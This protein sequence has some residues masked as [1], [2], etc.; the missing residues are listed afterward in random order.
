[1]GPIS[2]ENNSFDFCLNLLIIEFFVRVDTSELFR[3]KYPQ[4]IVLFAKLL[5]SLLDFLNI[6]ICWKSLCYDWCWI[7]DSKPVA[8]CQ[9]CFVVDFS[10]IL[11]TH[12]WVKVSPCL[13]EMSRPRKN[14]KSLFW[15][16][17]LEY[18]DGSVVVKL[19]IFF[20]FRFDSLVQL[21]Q[22][23]LMTTLCVS[24]FFHVH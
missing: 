1:M 12:H 19:L 23:F 20:A 15:L 3:I 11:T 10:T 2:G 24:E 16:E 5:N 22:S 4:I 13:R 14:L 9:E 7:I 8:S 17:I 6:S 18:F 21:M